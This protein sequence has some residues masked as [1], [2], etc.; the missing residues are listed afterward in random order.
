M[1]FPI[2]PVI[3]TEYCNLFIHFNG[4]FTEIFNSVYIYL[5]LVQHQIANEWA[6]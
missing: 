2:V 1:I 3:L 4:K 5:S 6:I